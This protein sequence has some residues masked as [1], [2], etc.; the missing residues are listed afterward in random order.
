MLHGEE[1]PPVSILEK[2]TAKGGDVRTR[3]VENFEIPPIRTGL[4]N[5]GSDSEEEGSKTPKEDKM[6]IDDPGS[7]SGRVTRGTR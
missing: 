7:G 3:T 1:P 4:A 5:G 6:E 2:L